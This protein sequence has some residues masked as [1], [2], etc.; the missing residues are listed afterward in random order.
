MIHKFWQQ[1]GDWVTSL[2]S[3]SFLWAKI[4]LSF[5]LSLTFITILITYNAFLSFEVRS[6][7]LDISRQIQNE[8]MRPKFLKLANKISDRVLYGFQLEDLAVLIMSLGV[9]Y[10]FAVWALKPIKESSRLQKE[11]VSY[12]THELKTP[13][14]TIKTGMEVFLRKKVDSGNLDRVL[15]VRRNEI[16]LDLEEIDRM[17]R[18]IDNLIKI[19][20]IDTYYGKFDYSKLNLSDLMAEVSGRMKHVAQSNRISL[21]FDKSAAVYHI[22]GDYGKLTDAIS[23]VLKNAIYYSKKGD[24]VKISMNKFSTYVQIR[25][26]DTGVGINK[27]DL[28]HIFDRFYRSSNTASRVNGDGLGL[29]ITKWIISNHG[30]NIKVQSNL[31]K[32]TV[33]KVL[34]PLET[35]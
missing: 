23:N 18:I 30:G 26:E 6:I 17:S 7:S 5:F 15:K 33:V 3:D 22:N 25:I 28:P 13:L 27:K 24:K 12:A 31:G 14:A 34:L 19:T 32:G 10:F 11:F 16:M 9:S 1:L 8:S 2:K 20:E 29:F 21:S 35:S 4:K